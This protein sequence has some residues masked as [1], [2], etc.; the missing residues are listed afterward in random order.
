[1]AF[2][3]IEWG[4]FAVIIGLVLAGIGVIPIAILATIVEGQWGVLGN[5]G[6][7]IVLTIG[8]RIFGYW[9][10]EKAAERAI[11]IAEAKARAEHATPARRLD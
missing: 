2:V 5:I 8:L 9:L 6:A 7:L 4:L 1:M 3:Y 10:V 11:T